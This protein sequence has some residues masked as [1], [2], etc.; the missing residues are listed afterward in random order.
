MSARSR[1]FQAATVAAATAALAGANPRRRFLVADEVGLGKTV[2]ARDTLATLATAARKF[3][4][5]Y[6]A[7]GHK[8][9]DQNKVELLRF[10]DQEGAKNALSTIDRVGL[11]PFETKRNGALA[12]YAF[13]PKT[14][15]SSAQRLYGG[16]AVERAFIKLLID[17]LYPGLADAFPKHYFEHGAT[18]GWSSA[19]TDA[20]A[21]FANVTGVFIASYGRA[22]RAEFGLPARDSIRKAVASEKS[23][24]SLGRLRKALAHAALDSAPPDLVILDEFQCY[25]D[26]LD[27]GPDNP[28]A[29]QLLNGKEGAASPPILLLSATPYRFYAERWESGTGVAPH[30]EL[31]AL[32]EFLGGGSVRK[33]AETRFRRF[34][35]LLHV[36][37][38]LAPESRSAKIAEAQEIKHQLEA[39]LIPLMSRTERPA[40]RSGNEPAPKP[41]RIEAHD[42]DVY[43]HFTVH[44]SPRLATSAIAYWLSVPLPAQALG[45]RYQISRD[46]D[47]PATRSVPRLGV[48]NCFKPPKDGWGSAKLRALNEIVPTETLALPW[49][50]PSLTWWEPSGPWAK[51]TASPKILVFSRFKATPQSLAALVSLEV[52]RKSVGRGNTPYAAAWKKRHLTPKANQGPTLALFHPSPFLIRA[53]NPLDA[54][55]AASLKQVRARVRQQIVRALPA[56]IKPQPPNAQGNRRRKPAWAV[57][58]AV[59]KAQKDPHAREFTMAQNDWG[60]VASQDATLQELLKQ[61]KQA[62]PI[63]WL[64]RWELDALVDM[65]IGAPGVVVGRALYR[66]LPALFD[67]NGKHFRRLVHF[68]WTRLRLYLDRPVFWAVLPGDDATR[69][70]QRAC[71]DGCFE[72]VLDEHFWLRKSKVAPEGLIDDLS[73]ALA[74]NIGTFGFKGAK[75]KDRIR[76]RCHAAVPFGGTE[77]ESQRQDQAAGAPPPARSEEIRSAFNTPFWPYVLAT[78]SV[79]QEGLDFHSWCDRLGHWDLCSNPVDLEQREGRVQRFGG[80][81]VRQPLAQKLGRHA[82]AEARR[83]LSSPW[84]VVARNA[85]LAFREDQAGLSPWWTMAGADLKRHLFALPQSRDIER[86]AKLRRQRLLYRLALGQPD[87]EDLVDLL[88]ENDPEATQLLQKLTL[89]LSAFS[90]RKPV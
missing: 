53:V 62:D 56:S 24:Q 89:D 45:D 8:V 78:T 66:H 31:F 46:I 28:L 61:R 65:A 71:V 38:R 68:C 15:F 52:E 6:I 55:D 85:D 11:I 50:L 84:D 76:I 86:F 26:L 2:V 64:S 4:V 18:T 42:L 80:L 32:I 22:L 21:K 63:T 59:E 23:G 7:S 41:V 54:R 40:L 19:C 77:T 48:T 70:F 88:T 83:E 33:A 39:L 90:H 30:I 58:A 29:F 69:K 20:E 34:G 9:A 87:Q 72:A 3:A 82:L 57:L 13:T 47:F 36:I 25:R 43:R 51:V 12:L 81:T 1:P 49:M 14:S 16:K 67:F 75:K 74:A 73:S 44:V 35:D 37:G 17:A 10:L 60:R 79:G 27:A 5:Y